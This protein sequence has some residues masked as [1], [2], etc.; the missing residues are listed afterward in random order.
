M[1]MPFKSLD[2]VFEAGNSN[3]N[4]IVVVIRHKDELFGFG[5]DEILGLQQIVLKPVKGLYQ[6][7]PLFSGAAI[8]GNGGIAMILDVEKVLS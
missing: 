2:T 6:E 1:I 5:V 7:Q 3:R 4:T 8:T